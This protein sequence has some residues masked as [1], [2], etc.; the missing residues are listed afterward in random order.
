MKFGLPLYNSNQIIE[1]FVYMRMNC[2]DTVKFSKLYLKL[3]NQFYNQFCSVDNSANELEFEPNRIN[4]FRFC[5]AA[6]RS[7]IG[8]DLEVSLAA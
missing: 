8:K 4:T 7:D 1:L 3:N 5:F 2:V 6:E